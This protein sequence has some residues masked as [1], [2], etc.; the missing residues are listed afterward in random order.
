MR[1]RFRF[2]HATVDVI[3]EGAEVAQV[4]Q[5]PSDIE[6]IGIVE[7][8]LG[9]RGALLLC[10]RVKN[11]SI[12]AASSAS[13]TRWRASGWAQVRKPLSNAVKRMR[14]VCNCRFAHS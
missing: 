14:R 12:A 7:G 4:G 5:P 2:E 8:G 1:E 13:Q 11:R 6:V 3:T 10:Q 9:A